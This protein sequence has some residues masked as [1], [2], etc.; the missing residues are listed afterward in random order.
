MSASVPVKTMDGH[1]EV[2]ERVRRLSQRHRTVLLLVDGKRSEQEVRRFAQRAGAGDGC[3]DDLLELGL[4][5]RTARSGEA[6][7][8]VDIPIG[9]NN[10]PPLAAATADGPES[11]LPAAHTLPPESVLNDSVLGNSVLRAFDALESARIEDAP[12][13]EARGILMRAVRSEAPLSGSLTLL[14]LR[15]ARTRRDLVEL[16]DEVEARIV[17]PYR[18]LSAQQTLNRARRLLATPNDDSP[19]D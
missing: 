17:K 5:A 6:P 15:R 12:L 8:H 2:R 4:I 9:E 19:A 7:L 16:I 3:F 11:L 13:E 14:R 10:S 18:S 1:A